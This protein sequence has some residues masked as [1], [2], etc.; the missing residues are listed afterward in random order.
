MRSWSLAELVGSPMAD[1][2]FSFV[3]WL[4]KSSLSRLKSVLGVELLG[5]LNGRG[6][7]NHVVFHPVDV[8]GLDV[9]GV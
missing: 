4:L 9:S 8:R 2:F 3:K 1:L 5:L 6:L 7:S